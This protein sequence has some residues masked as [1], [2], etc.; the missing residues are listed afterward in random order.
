M[1]ELDIETFYPHLRA[2]LDE[3]YAA[4]DD[5]AIESAF[6]EAFGEGI[7]PA[8]YES[9]FSGLGKA[10]NSVAPVLKTV[11]QGALSGAS[12]GMA[13]GPYGA[14]AGALAGAGGAALKNYG[15]KQLRGVGS[16]ISG[17]VNTAGALTGG[18]GAAGQG[19]SALSGLLGRGG[20]PAT[21]ALRGVLQRPETAA[22]LASLF[23]GRN[24]ALPVGAAGTPVPASAFAGLLG[25]L[26]R[27]AEAEFADAFDDGAPGYLAD[28]FGRLVVD[29]GASEQRAARLLQLL[30]ETPDEGWDDS[31]ERDD[32][33]YDDA[34]DDAF[35]DAFDDALDDAYDDALDDAVDEAYDDALDDAWDD[36][37]AA[38]AARVA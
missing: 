22:A 19:L 35:D 1:S 10:L 28:S 27:E 23:A 15:P 34:Y 12:S 2:A 30:A 26:A 21:S 6:T 38:R 5:A 33:A 24:T 14:L 8:E 29:P 7:T 17:V 9:F 18:G 3:R 37:W 20:G 16:A 13:L 31:D 25:S 11:G 36:S 4:L 32:D